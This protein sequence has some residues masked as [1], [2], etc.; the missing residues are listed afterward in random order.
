LTSSLQTNNVSPTG[1]NAFPG[2]GGCPYSDL[3]VYYF[4]GRVDTEAFA[5]ER[6]FLGN[7]REDPCSFLF[8]SRPSHTAVE[9]FL[10]NHPELRLL[11][12]FHLDYAQWQGKDLV[13]FQVGPIEVVPYWFQEDASKGPPEKDQPLI[14]DPGLVF[15]SGGHPTTLDCLKALVLLFQDQTPSTVLDLGT[16]TGL[17]ALAAARLGSNRV[18]AVDLNP[19]AARTALRNFRLNRLENN[20]LAIQGDAEEFIDCTADLVIANLHY[21]VVRRLILKKGFSEKRW[22]LCSGL[23]RSEARAVME[24]PALRRFE[25]VKSWIHEGIWH[26]YL[27]QNRC[28]AVE[29]TSQ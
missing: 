17:L 2:T 3:Y 5:S 11:D 15:G 18:L 28:D 14:L 21:D 8:F 19:L 7:W 6:A 22:V 27:F 13:P 24:N 4:D 16:G 29:M 25:I 23:L 26:T 1:P 9:A 12:R 20:L 10:E